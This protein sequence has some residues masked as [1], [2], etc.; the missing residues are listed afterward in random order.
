MKEEFG[1]RKL[2]PWSPDTPGIPKRK[3]NS[4]TQRLTRSTEAL[5]GGKV[6]VIIQCKRGGEE[7]TRGGSVQT[8]PKRGYEF[9][10]WNRQE[11]NELKLKA[12]GKKNQ[13]SKSD[14]E[15]NVRGTSDKNKKQT[16]KC[17][18]H[19]GELP[20]DPIR[21]NKNKA[22]ETKKGDQPRPYWPPMEMSAGKE[23]ERGNR[24]LRRDLGEK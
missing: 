10:K 23:H 7:I 9:K 5:R 15:E 18:T 1:Q 21:K 8:T 13:E 2:R 24:K 20:T 3:D 12:R 11:Y 4:H 14:K 6:F 22:W 17:P 19:R 16:K